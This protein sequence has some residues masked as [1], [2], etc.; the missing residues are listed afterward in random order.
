MLISP[1]PCQL[2]KSLSCGEHKQ[3]THPSFNCKLAPA[4]APRWVDNKRSPNAALLASVSTAGL[5]SCMLTT[6]LARPPA[7]SAYIK[8]VGSSD[9]KV[10]VAHL[11]FDH[12]LAVRGCSWTSDGERHDTLHAV[13]CQLQHAVPLIH[14][15][16]LL[17]PLGL[18]ALLLAALSLQPSNS[19]ARPEISP[20]ISSLCR[21]S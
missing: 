1:L 4:A 18:S 13:R 16:D 2:T 19:P 7:R 21:R 12:T 5:S 10:W 6:P 14:E 9:C 8:N 17:V 15:V 3:A 11:Q 20:L